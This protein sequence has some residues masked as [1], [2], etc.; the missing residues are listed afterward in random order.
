VKNIK[1]IWAFVLM[2][3]LAFSAALVLSCS[4]VPENDSKTLTGIEVTTLPTQVIYDLNEAFASAGMV[5][6]ATYSDGSTAKVTGYTVFGFSSSTEGNKTITIIYKGETATFTVEVVNSNRVAKPVADPAGGT[7]PTDFEVTLTTTTADAEIWYTTNGNTPSKGG[8]TSTKYTAPIAISA[9]VTIK[10]IA[11]K[12]GMTNSPILEAAYTVRNFATWNNWLATKYGKSFGWDAANVSSDPKTP[13]THDMLAEEYFFSKGLN[14]G[15]NLG[16][17]HDGGSNP[18]ATNGGNYDK[19]FAGIKASGINVIRIP[20]SWNAGSSGDGAL[21]VVSASLLND[22]EA[23]ILAAHGAGLVV[24]I[25]SHHDKSFFSLD[26][27]GAS[28]IASLQED[29]EP[30]ADADLIS[31]TERYKAVWRQIAERFRDYGDWLIFEALN[32]PTISSGGSVQWD[33]A[34]PAYHEVLNRWC[35]AFV[36]TVRADGGN[37]AK[38]YLIFKSYAGKLQQSLDPTNGFRIPTDPVG[39]GRLVYSFHSYVP[40]GLGLEGTSINWTDDHA[41]LYRSAFVQA[42]DAYIKQ[43]IPVFMGETGATFH[44]QRSSSAA[45]ADNSILANRNRLLLLNAL[46]YYA[47]QYSVIPCLWD[48]GEA[49]RTSASQ[50]NG[51]T[52]AMFRRKSAHDM[53]SDDW[54]KPIDHTQINGGS[55]YVANVTAAAGAGAMNANNAARDDPLFGE[56]TI[57]AFVD[58]VNGRALFGSPVLSPKLAEL[59]E[60]YK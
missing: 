23:A 41:D 32:E 49:T 6:T 50:P 29:A 37:N 38:R 58:A 8:A 14:A 26:R 15:W 18:R 20:V 28:L 5:V 33:G 36:E 42:S 17:T 2:A 45:A 51:E 21:T 56:Y 25:N 9:T 19:L 55:A 12:Y 48:N 39:P 60:P 34:L 16:N 31:F 11:V 57:K 10:A 3:A 46:G 4:D 40:Q 54:G 43:G 35:Q 30:G 27:A 13:I 59:Y 52:F 47:R 44:S 22:V 24:F 7:I 1:K 53:D